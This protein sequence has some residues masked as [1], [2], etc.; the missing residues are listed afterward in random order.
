MI[1]KEAL[2][3][4]LKQSL[5]EFRITILDKRKKEQI[6]KEVVENLQ[7][8]HVELF[9]NQK[10]NLRNFWSCLLRRNLCCHK[11]MPSAFQVI[12]STEYI[13]KSLDVVNSANN[14]RKK[15]GISIG[16]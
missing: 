13:E 16:V 14:R 6:S 9:E 15:H 11:F 10:T 4:S 1:P 5:E 8:S 3:E 12:H 7:V 2:T